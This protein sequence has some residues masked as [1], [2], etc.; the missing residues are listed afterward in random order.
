MGKNFT[1]VK[2]GIAAGTKKL[3]AGVNIATMGIEILAVSAQNIPTTTVIELQPL[4]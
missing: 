3:S 2:M 4:V 1:K